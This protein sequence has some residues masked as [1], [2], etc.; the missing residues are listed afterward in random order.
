MATGPRLNIIHYTMYGFRLLWNL[1]IAG[2]L[3]SVFFDTVASNWCYINV[4]LAFTANGHKIKFSCFYDIC[5]VEYAKS[6]SFQFQSSTLFSFCIMWNDESLWNKTLLPLPNCQKVIATL[7]QQWGV[8]HWDKQVCVALVIRFLTFN[9]YACFIRRLTCA[10]H[11]CYM[12]TP[13]II[14]M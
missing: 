14:S 2:K 5:Q 3:D 13:L 11:R 1:I 6:I 9:L 8:T 4:R 10:F 12:H 7:A